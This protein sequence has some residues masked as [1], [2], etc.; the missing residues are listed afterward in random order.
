MIRYG[1]NIKTKH[2]QRVDNIL[3]MA[4]TQTDAERRLRQMYH[5]C[6]IVDCHEQSVPR[7]VDT[8]DVEG[9]ISLISAAPSSFQ[10]AGTH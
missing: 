10:K 3:I 2:G 9:V 1:F 7:R 8:L 5:Y 6:E 4:A